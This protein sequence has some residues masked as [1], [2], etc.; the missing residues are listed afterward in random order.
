MVSPFVFLSAALS[1]HPAQSQAPKLR[2][3]TPVLIVERIEPSL[4]LWVDRLGFQKTIEVPEG[5]HLGFVALV[6]DGIEIMY[7]TRD[8]VR[9]EIV[10]DGL[11]EALS[12]SPDHRAS[13]YCEVE[14][15]D[16]VRQALEGLEILLEYRK[17]FYG[18]E[19]LFL[20]EPGGHIVAFAVFPKSP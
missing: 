17:T 15:L 12:P 8:S 4:D 3:V 13:L 5:D 2:K 14:D 16:A 20:R 1:A 6:R 9:A 18:A 7:Q 19:E 10:N 11:P